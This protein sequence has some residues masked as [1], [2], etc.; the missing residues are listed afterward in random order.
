MGLAAGLALDSAGECGGCAPFAM[1]AFHCEHFT[2]QLVPGML[3]LKS[4]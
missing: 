2:A 3:G 1:A 4:K